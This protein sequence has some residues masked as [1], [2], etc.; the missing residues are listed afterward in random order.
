MKISPILEVRIEAARRLGCDVELLD[1]E[2]GYLVVLRLGDRHRVLQGGISPLNN[3]MAFQLATDKYHASVLLKRAGFQVPRSARC[4][5][6]GFFPD[7]DFTAHTG[8]E[9][10]HALVEALGFPVLIKPNRGSRGQWIQVVHT[11]EA[12]EA[13]VREV[14]E[15]D[16]LALVQEV[17]SGM[18]VRL[19]FL[20]GEY[21]L[22]YTRRPVHLE[23]DGRSTVRQLLA[24]QDPRFSREEF[25]NRMIRD[26]LWPRDAT[27]E[28]VLPAGTLLDAAT[29]IL[30]LNRPCFAEPL[31]ELPEPWLRA[32]LAVGRVLG[33]RHFGVDF[34]V[35]G[36]REE[37]EAAFVLEVNAS[38]SMVQMARMGHREWAVRAEEKVVRAI[39]GLGPSV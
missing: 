35:A 34:R 2:T 33:L 3:A 11:G 20:D 37:V 31:R 9:G 39:L 19:D 4:L 8:F 21:L 5:K 26:P 18:D 30:N 28:A 13:A 15:R 1:G 38:P 29:P 25:L 12:L 6:P 32:G 10:A 27:P 22:G 24:R 23:G 7:E 36:E 14:W 17:I 16:Y